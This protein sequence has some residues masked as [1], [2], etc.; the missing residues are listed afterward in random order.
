MRY[1]SQKDGG[2][3]IRLHDADEFAAMRLAGRIAADTLDF[4]E[5]H[6]RPGISTAEL[7]RRCEAFMREAGAIPATLGYHGYRHA[8]CISVNQVVTHGIP[9][10]REIL[11]TGDIVNID[12]TPKFAGWHG[13]SSRTY[14][15]G[16][17]SPLAERLIDT[18]HAALLAGIAE[19]RPGATLGDVGAAIDARV[20]AAG[21]RGVED[22]CGHGLGQ[23]FHAAPDVLHHG[24]RGTGIVLEPGMF[25]TI[26]PMVNAGTHAVKVLKDGWT[27]VT[28]DGALSAQFEHSLAV[29]EDGVELFTLGRAALANA[30][31]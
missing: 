1:S 27:T 17:V 26:E 31:T 9:S 29:T 23:V 8:S 13:D 14:K 22:F 5:A 28:R 18:A 3:R 6:V 10:E 2:R 15:V 25:F 19:V 12:V 16:P 7:D 24:Q 11:K 21:F 30:V 20:R 4:I